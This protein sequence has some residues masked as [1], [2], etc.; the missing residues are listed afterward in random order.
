VPAVEENLPLG[1]VQAPTPRL[2]GIEYSS[3][4]SR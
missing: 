4:F 2:M 3:S 1:H